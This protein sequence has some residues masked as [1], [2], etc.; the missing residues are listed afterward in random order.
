MK[1]SDVMT[2]NV[3]SVQP[4][5]SVEHAAR[6]MLQK[7]ISGMPVIDAAG[8]LVGMI[9]EGDFLRRSEIGT[10]R[11]RNR[12][13]EFLMG[14][15]LLSEEYVRIS[16][17]K[18]EE[19]MTPDVHTVSAAAPLEEVV[20][21]MERYHV[22]R[23]PVVHGKRVV[24]MITRANLMQALLNVAPEARPV[25]ADDAQI[26]ERLLATLK[27]QPWAPVAMIQVFVK[28]GVVTLSGALTDERERQA[29]R[30]AAE[31]TPGVKKV[32]DEMV[33]VEPFSGMVIEPQPA[34]ASGT[35]S[36][37]KTSAR[38]DKKKSHV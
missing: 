4:D 32:K 15:G 26:R 1:A 8:N 2:E 27:K 34:P 38:P 16:G 5:S 9:T 6:L 35:A 20:R 19:V 18:V 31:N 11:P 12:W 14:P 21:L 37:A 3:I 22:K 33:W 17:R 24:G 29:L 23:L 36:R 30:V 10:Q 7:R 25:S 13:I 28:D